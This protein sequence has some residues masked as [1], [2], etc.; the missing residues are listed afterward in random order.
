MLLFISKI[1]KINYKKILNDNNIE[2][3]KL[4]IDNKISYK[5]SILYG[6]V[7]KGSIILVN[8]LIQ[9]YNI[10][11]H[12]RCDFLFRHSCALGQLDLAKWLYY[13]FDNVDIYTWEN[14][15]CPCDECNVDK[16]PLEAFRWSCSN[17]H[18]DVAK[19]L[20]SLDK[21]IDVYYG[22]WDSLRWSCWG[23]HIDVVKWLYQID[24]DVDTDIFIEILSVYHNNPNIFN[25]ILSIVYHPTIKL[26]KNKINVDK[27]LFN[28]L[29][30]NGIC[31]DNII[32]NH[33]KKQYSAKIY[34][35]VYNCMSKYLYTDC[36]IF[37]CSFIQ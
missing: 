21:T 6:A 3:I 36:I 31:S 30:S 9:N 34:E 16:Y 37:C 19:W 8:H 10:D 13:E 4:L 12:H 25:W 27:K 17:G 7:R 14:E 2:Y 15:E 1:K 35:C 18:L 24:S 32:N 22:Y 23:G 28:V 33:V 5:Y 20:Y 11:P 26:I 29:F